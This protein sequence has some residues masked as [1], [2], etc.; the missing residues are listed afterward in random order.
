[1]VIHSD[2][3]PKNMSLTSYFLAMD[4]GGAISNS[5]DGCCS[6]EY[7]WKS[8]GPDGSTQ[9]YENIQTK[10]SNI[11]TNSIDNPKTNNTLVPNK[12]CLLIVSKTI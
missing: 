7:F 1:M 3:W 11:N 2:L 10:Y 6:F 12:V 8:S 5:P 4:L 9:P